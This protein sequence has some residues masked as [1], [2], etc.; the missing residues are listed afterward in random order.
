MITFSELVKNILA[1]QNK[2]TENLFIDNVI[3]KNT[4]YKYKQRYPSLNSVIKI[5][6]YL[7]VSID[8]LFNL[9]DEN[10][11]SGNYS[12]DSEIFYHNLSTFIKNKN[13]SFRKFCRDLNYSPDNILRWKK[14]VVP[15]VANLLEIAKYLN[16]YIDDLLL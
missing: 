13:I 2:S 1:E 6:N 14:G 9:K 5:A 16:C 11:F 3:S 15:S 8:Y 12:F 7:K 10:D 4:F